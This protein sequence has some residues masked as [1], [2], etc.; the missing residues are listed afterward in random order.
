MTLRLLVFGFA[1]ITLSTGCGGSK[2][3]FSVVTGAQKQ[4][5]GNN[6][7]QSP[8]TS[9]SLNPEDTVNF[10][11]AQIGWNEAPYQ[12]TQMW[13]WAS[14]SPKG[15]NLPYWWPDSQDPKPAEQEI[16]SGVGATPKNRE[17]A[18]SFEFSVP[19][20]WQKILD[21]IAKLNIKPD[22]TFYINYFIKDEKGAVVS[23]GSV[24]MG[25]EIHNALQSNSSVKIGNRLYSRISKEIGDD[26]VNDFIKTV[27]T[28]S[29]YPSKP[30]ELDIASRKQTSDLIKKIFIDDGL[31]QTYFFSGAHAGNRSF[32]VNGLSV[33][34]QDN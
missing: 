5:V 28:P 13:L 11:V 29:P 33:S 4:I 3:P 20:S 30:T 34:I 31:S 8:V 2:N 19:I 14:L 32:Q 9:R 18:R 6:L 15:V 21:T 24:E 10:D 12:S 25:R 26:D 22:E 17:G 23:Q 27:A 16:I 1:L 7:D